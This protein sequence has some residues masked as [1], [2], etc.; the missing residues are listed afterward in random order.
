[1]IRTYPHGVTCWVD[2]RTPDVDASG[3]FYGQLFGWQLT[4]ATPPGAPQRYAVATLGGRD[5]AGIGG[6]ARADEPVEWRTYVAVDDCD[7]AAAQVAAAGGHVVTT[8]EDAG[9]G[10]RSAEVVDPQ[11]ARLFLWQAR[12]RPGAQAVNVPGAWN[13]SDLHTSYP[14]GASDFYEQ[15]FEWQVDLTAPGEAM[16]RVPG[17]GDHLAKTVDPGI[18]ERQKQAPEGFADVIG[19]ITGRMPGETSHWHVTFSVA[20]RDASTATVERLGGTVLDTDE[21]DWSRSARVRD[22]Q[23]AVLTLSQFTPPGS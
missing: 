20:D 23:G 4:Q 2:L 18:R 8:P 13:F 14:G 16:I 15:V 12:R 11:G 21:D 22:P 6:P 19:A 3:R 1:M 10:G 17:Y 9:P 7:R 5:V